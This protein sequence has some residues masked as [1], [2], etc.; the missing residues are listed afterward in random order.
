MDLHGCFVNEE[1]H[2]ISM[3]V[4]IAKDASR[5]AARTGVERAALISTEP[6]RRS[7]LERG[8]RSDPLHAHD[9]NRLE[10][11]RRKVA[12]AF[13]HALENRRSIRDRKAAEHA[14]RAFRVEALAGERAQVPHASGKARA[15]ESIGKLVLTEGHLPDRAA[16][17]LPC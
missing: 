14:A 1:V 6:N 16:P 3:D 2:P 15:C 8:A 17:Q 10:A 5:P 7:E 9:A 13:A 12:L 11:H 4:V